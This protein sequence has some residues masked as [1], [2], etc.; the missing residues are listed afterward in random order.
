MA[1]Q[2]VAASSH[3]IRLECPVCLFVPKKEIYQC[4][5]GHSI[6]HICIAKIVVCPI[7]RVA[8][9]TVKI[10]NHY[11]ETFLDGMQFT[12]IWKDTGCDAMIARGELSMHETVCKYGYL[13]FL[14]NL[15]KC[16]S[17][18]CIHDLRI[19]FTGQSIFVKLLNAQRNAPFNFQ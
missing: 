16:Y 14:N 1:S 11:A 13:S 3:L 2:S 4:K 7:C 18:F 12:C 8:V 9:D 5:N 6:C 19:F 15:L 10:R 17:I